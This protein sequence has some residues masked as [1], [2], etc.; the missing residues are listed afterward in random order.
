MGR[1]YVVNIERVLLHEILTLR[2]YNK[3][4]TKKECRVLMSE[5]MLE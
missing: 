1:W 5:Q 4:N 3:L 2:I